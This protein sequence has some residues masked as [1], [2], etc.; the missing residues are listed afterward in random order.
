MSNNN[1]TNSNDMLKLSHRNLLEALSQQSRELSTRTVLFHHLIGERLGLNP[2]DY[3]CLD[4][5][6]RSKTPM[7]ASQLGEETNLSTVQ[8]QVL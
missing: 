6:I 4:V 8:S 3:K 1:N 5:I 7:W 2:I